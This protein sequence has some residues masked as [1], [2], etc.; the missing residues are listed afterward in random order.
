M[1]DEV[2]EN[3]VEALMKRGTF[4][5]FRE[6]WMQLVLEGMWN[7]VEYALKDSRKMTDQLEEC[8][9]SKRMKSVLKENPFKHHFGEVY[10][11]CFRSPMNFL[12][13]FV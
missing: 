13:A 12:I 9:D 6:E 5:V 4:G 11:I 7:T 8:S 1:A 3:T 10:F 2:L